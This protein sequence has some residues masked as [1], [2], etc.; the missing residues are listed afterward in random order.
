MTNRVGT[1]ARRAV[2][3]LQRRTGTTPPAP[4]RTGFYAAVDPGPGRRGEVLGTEPLDAGPA[5]DG[6]RVRYR[7]LDA[8]GQPVAAS[9]ALA[10]PAG[11]TDRPRPVVVW[12]HGARGVAPGCGPSRAGLE[13]WYA[14]EL[15]RAGAVVAAPDLTGLGMEGTVHPYL[16]G[17]TAGRSVLD[18]ARAAADLTTAAAGNVV[19][20][21][22]HSAGGFAVLWANE[23]AG[24]TD[25]E[26]LDVRLAVPMSPVADLAVALAHFATTRRFGSYAVQVAGTWD[27]VE[28][29]AAADVLTPA[30]LKRLH[31]L[32]TDTL[33]GLNRAFRGEPAQWIRA[34][35]FRHGAWAAAL[36][37]QSAG[38]TAGAAPLLLVHGDADE[39]LPVRWSKQVAAELPDAELR[40]YA[41][42]DHMSIHD[43]AHRDV[44][45]RILDALR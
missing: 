28:D 45:D 44:V 39:I 9:M 34:D 2:T 24:D 19:A 26:G 8:A 17:T 32:R 41:G 37:R 13:A 40:T 7:T 42:A 14:G 6:W 16:H 35:G 29:V 4:D 1:F 11:I 30:A 23:L 18:A 25:G 43:A 5:A 3:S 10:I 12:V 27:G 38:R 36:E 33:G 15:L 20:L 21:A 31:R 22:G